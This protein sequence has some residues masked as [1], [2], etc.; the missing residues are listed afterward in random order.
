VTAFVVYRVERLSEG[1]LSLT[2]NGMI[3][4]LWT[5]GKLRGNPKPCWRCGRSMRAGEMT[6]RPLGEH[7]HRMRRLCGACV[8]SL[9]LWR[10]P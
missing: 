2:C 3:S 9:V 10:K 5:R 7:V 6:F 8:D 1:T 4:D